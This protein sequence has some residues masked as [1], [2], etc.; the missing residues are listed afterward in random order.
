ML[1]LVCFFYGC[2]DYLLSRLCIAYPRRMYARKTPRFIV[3]RS[4]ET[5]CSPNTTSRNRRAFGVR[6]TCTKFIREAERRLHCD[7][8]KNTFTIKYLLSKDST[9]NTILRRQMQS[10]SNKRCNFRCFKCRSSCIT[11]KP[12]AHS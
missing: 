5:R 2:V 7:K 10:L 6:G 12:N 4:S 3:A 8:D 1:T 11:R 9:K